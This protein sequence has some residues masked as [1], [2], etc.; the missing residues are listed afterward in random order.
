MVSGFIEKLEVLADSICRELNTLCI[1]DIEDPD[2]Y[3]KMLL[4]IGT[5]VE[6]FYYIDPGE[7]IED[8][9]CSSKILSMHGEVFNLAVRR[10]YIVNI[11]EDLFI[12]AV[13]KLIEISK[14]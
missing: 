4:F 7:C 6:S 10:E 12:K 3:E 8:V 11:N 13:E 2:L 1:S 14:Y 9:D 5:W